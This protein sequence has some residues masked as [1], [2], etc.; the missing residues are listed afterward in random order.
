MSKGVR[1]VSDLVADEYAG[2]IL[3]LT[4]SQPR[5]VQEI[6]ALTG[7]PVAVAYRRVSALEGAGLIKCS[8]TEVATTGKKSKYYICQVEM[9]RFTFREGRFEV[10]IEWKDRSSESHL[11]T[12]MTC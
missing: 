9:V 8:R 3:S 10:E 7:I 11:K 5:C 6:C 12:P 2:K 1:P 4:F